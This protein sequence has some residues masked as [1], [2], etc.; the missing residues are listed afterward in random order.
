MT[1]TE[2]DSFARY[3]RQTRFAPLGLA[4]QRRLQ[5]SSCLI[6]GCGA[7]GSVQANLL[8][9]A[10]V[11]R[12]RL[13][14]RDFVELTNLQRQDLYGETDAEQGIPKAIAAARELKRIN[15]Q[16][17]LDPVVGDFSADNAEQIA[18]GFDLILDGADNFE[19]RFL[20]NDVAC[21]LRIPWVFGGC[22]ASEGQVMTICPGET[23]CLLCL[24]P[25][26]P[27]A[28]GTMATCDTA[29]IFNAASHWVATL[30]AA[31]A[32]KLLS[33]NPPKTLP[34]LISIDA[35]EMSFRSLDVSGLRDRRDCRCCD[36]R[37]FEW[38]E[39]AR[40]AQTAIL[41]GRNAVQ[42]SPAE[43]TS[44]ALPELA[45]RLRGLGDV[46]EQAYLVRFRSGELTVTM[47]ADGRAIVQGT[48]EISVARSLCARVLGSQ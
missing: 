22:V 13:V 5:A 21:K 25:E 41:C 2:H 39:G 3:V 32:I 44:I 42:I 23:P 29:G 1:S 48:E 28:V 31:E 9:R 15:S 19:T 12:I 36:Q 6:V 27:P 47:F 40:T 24:M 34:R 7:L 20:I 37:R 43:R 45:R 11:G 46:E 38:L 16:I 18:V 26:G 33:G 30:Q 17:E 10:G 8:A 35:W 4:G 14:D